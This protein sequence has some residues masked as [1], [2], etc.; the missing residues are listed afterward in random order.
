MNTAVP[1]LLH[2]ERLTKR[3]GT[4]AAV[5]EVSLSVSEGERHALIGPNGAGKTTLFHL[6][7]G[8]LSAT[9][10]RILFR[11]EDVTTAREHARARLG[12]A[13]TFQQGSL[14]DRLECLDNVAIAVQRQVGAGHRAL[15]ARSRY[16]DVVERSAQLLASVGLSDK[17]RDPAGE[18]AHGERRRLELA[19][20]MA[21]EPQLVM[22]DE[23]A[24]GMSQEEREQFLEMILGF[25][26]R[27][28][29]LLVEHDM[30]VVFAL[31]TRVSVL[32]A[33]RLLADGTPEEIRGSAEVEQAY[34]GA[35][36]M[37][38]LFKSA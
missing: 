21:T 24:A 3:F 2:L 19:V 35:E 34:L 29:V 17:A 10:G 33:G 38:K 20:A 27:I 28:T 6:V 31:A 11:G 4:L 14:F 15:R 18:L 22:L 25:P 1:L 16:P 12:I 9:S 36:G 13:R 32:D 23:P 8:A 5:D 26:D 7:S 30:D 37:D